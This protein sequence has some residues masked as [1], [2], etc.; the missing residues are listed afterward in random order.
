VKDPIEFRLAKDAIYLKRLNGKE[1]KFPL[2]TFL[3]VI[4]FLRQLTLTTSG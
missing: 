4:V 2:I 3:S 1:M